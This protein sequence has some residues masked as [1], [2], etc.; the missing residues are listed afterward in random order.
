MSTKKALQDL[1]QK[2]IAKMA[3]KAIDLSILQITQSIKR[4]RSMCIA[5]ILNRTMKVVNGLC[6]LS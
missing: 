3:A 4:V 1:Q 2:H 5:L 6:L